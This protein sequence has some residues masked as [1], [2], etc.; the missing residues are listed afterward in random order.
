MKELRNERRLFWLGAKI[1]VNQQP[2]HT[3]IVVEMQFMSAKGHK[4]L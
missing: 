2:K 3:L 1:I 4:L